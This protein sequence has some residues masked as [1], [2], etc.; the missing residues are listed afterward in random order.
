MHTLEAVDNDAN[1]SL[2]FE[3]V[4]GNEDGVFNINSSTGEVTLARSGALDPSVRASYRLGVTVVDSVGLSDSSFLD[5]EVT[6]RPPGFHITLLPYQQFSSLTAE[7]IPFLTPEQVATIPNSWWFSRIPSESRAA[8]SP[9]QLGSLNTAQ[10]G[11][12]RLLTQEQRL[13]LP[14]DR[15]AL[16]PYTDLVFV[17]AQRANE[18]TTAQLASLPNSWW[19][20][21]ISPETRA[22]LNQTQINAIDFSQSG[23]IDSL[24]QSQI[25]LLNTESLRQLDF[26][27]FSRL[28]PQQI[29]QLSQE[30]LSAVPGYYWF[31]RISQESRDALSDAGIQWING[32]FVFG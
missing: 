12:L 32:R 23:M 29:L 10:A 25:E 24:T 19:F 8:L 14:S 17:P 13:T 18:I 7:E 30:Q 9:E 6:V 28:R 31:I 11:M 15:Y 16:V 1:E 3:I 26:T 20:R 5:I 21:Q 22:S 4:T 27:S 2:R